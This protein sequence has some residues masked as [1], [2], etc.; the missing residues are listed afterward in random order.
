M[1]TLILF[2]INFILTINVYS[3]SY[4]RL[5]P[6]RDF[7]ILTTDSSV[8]PITLTAD[9]VFAIDAVGN[10]AFIHSN[11]SRITNLIK[12]AGGGYLYTTVNAGLTSI[13]LVMSDY[14]F[15]SIWNKSFS[16]PGLI[17]VWDLNVWD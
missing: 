2:Q 14:A 9:S 16:N 15:D 13:E 11:P 8:S 4:E 3:Q 17:S 7:R 1:K 5:Y 10:L 12:M 6:G